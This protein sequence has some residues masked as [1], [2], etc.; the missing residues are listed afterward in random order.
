MISDRRLY[1]SRAVCPQ[2]LFK[3]QGS[4]SIPAVHS[5][6]GR[7]HRPTSLSASCPYESPS[8]GTRGNHIVGL[9]SARNFGA[10]LASGHFWISSRKIRG[11]AGNE[12]DAG[13]VRRHPFADFLG[14]AVA[15]EYRFKLLCF[16]KIDFNETWYSVC[17]NCRIINVFA[18][19]P[20][21]LYE[22][23]FLLFAFL[24]VR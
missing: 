22:Q 15:L 16:L 21:P 23:T 19:L 4:T 12:P 11:I 10:I 8:R 5:P 13:N 20:S 18:D 3:V 17:P 24:P 1:L 14:G 2:K 9:S 6:R 7:N